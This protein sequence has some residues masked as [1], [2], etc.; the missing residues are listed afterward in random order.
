MLFVDKSPPQCSLRKEG[1]R[2]GELGVQR[3][4]KVRASLCQDGNDKDRHL[5]NE[6]MG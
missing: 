6:P 3:V 1:R 5:W 4:N 2:I